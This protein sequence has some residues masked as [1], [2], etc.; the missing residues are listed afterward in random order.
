M[1]NSNEKSLKVINETIFDKIKRFINKLLRKE[2]NRVDNLIINNIKE[3]KQEIEANIKENQE[4]TINLIKR[5][6][7][8]EINLE[9]KESNGVEEINANLARYLEKI[10]KEI[11][12]SKTE[13]SIEENQ[14]KSY[15]EQ[16]EKYQEKIAN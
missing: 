13:K 7:K 5:I 14:I 12:R 6:E 4:D 2:D 16:M 1:K 8:E 3:E 11:D 9:E 10:Q 15:R